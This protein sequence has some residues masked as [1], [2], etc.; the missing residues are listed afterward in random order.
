MTRELERLHELQAQLSSARK[1]EDIA[2]AA[3][4][5]YAASGG[6]DTGRFKDLLNEVSVAHGVAL[7]VFRAWK[8]TAERLWAP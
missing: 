6:K 4:D 5:A 8:E 2:M 7:R 3:L 1:A